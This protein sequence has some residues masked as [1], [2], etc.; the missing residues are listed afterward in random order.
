M[1]TG[2]LLC[3]HSGGMSHRP[4]VCNN[5]ASINMFAL[6]RWQLH[7]RGVNCQMGYSVSVFQLRQPAVHHAGQG[8]QLACDSCVHD[9]RWHRPACAR[10]NGR[11]D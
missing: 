5:I 2:R 8:R 10:G 6:I 11:V 9:T 4:K 3:A 7:P 1:G